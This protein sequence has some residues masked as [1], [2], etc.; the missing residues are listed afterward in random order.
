MLCVAATLR[1]GHALRTHGGIN[2]HAQ[3]QDA[4]S[5]AS[6]ACHISPVIM[7]GTGRMKVTGWGRRGREA[8]GKAFPASLLIQAASMG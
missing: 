5:G 2:A 8:D 4:R 1:R 7:V 3:R 6:G